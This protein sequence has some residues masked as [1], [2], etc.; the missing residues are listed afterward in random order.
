LNIVGNDYLRR[1]Q[2]DDRQR[3]GFRTAQDELLFA[4]SG[5]CF[6]DRLFVFRRRS[7]GDQRKPADLL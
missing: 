3:H 6:S 2:R 4:C 1:I 5:N 7:R